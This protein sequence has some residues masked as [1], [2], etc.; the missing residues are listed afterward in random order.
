MDEL[1]KQ[2]LF[3]QYLGQVWS[4]ILII[5]NLAKIALAIQDG[6]ESLFPNRTP[7]QV[8]DEYITSPKSLFYG[9]DKLTEEFNRTTAD[10]KIPEWLPGLRHA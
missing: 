8:G 6:E 10:I 5:E 3:F 7:Y 4:R 9:F 2:K 1:E